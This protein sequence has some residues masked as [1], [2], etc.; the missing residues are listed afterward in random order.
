VTVA[1]T[2]RCRN[3]ITWTALPL[4]VT[5]PWRARGWSDLR[6]GDEVP[7]IVASTVLASVWPAAAVPPSTRV[8]CTAWLAA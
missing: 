6:A 3:G 4:T 2:G 1:R 5:W 7:S 8:V